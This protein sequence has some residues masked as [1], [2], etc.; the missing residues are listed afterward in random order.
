[1][2]LI[3]W[4]VLR[5]FGAQIGGIALMGALVAVSHADFSS[6]GVWG[7]IASAAIATLVSI[8]N[9]VLGSAPK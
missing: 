8:A 9:E 7:P 1:M 5:H 2:Q 4:N 3:T 6:L